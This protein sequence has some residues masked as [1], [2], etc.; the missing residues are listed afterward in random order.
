MTFDGAHSN[1]L[2]DARGI[3]LVCDWNGT[4]ADDVD[5]AVAAT[6]ATLRAFGALGIDRRA[7]EESFRLP[8]EGFFLELGIPAHQCAEAENRWNREMLT[9]GPPRSLT[10]RDGDARRR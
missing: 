6:S 8:L 2:D 5:R 7:F 10:W 1:N 4:I 9:L 3:L